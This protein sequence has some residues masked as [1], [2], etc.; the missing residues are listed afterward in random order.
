[1]RPRK[2]KIHTPRIRESKGIVYMYCPVCNVRKGFFLH[3]FTAVTAAMTVQAFRL[4]H[5]H[6]LEVNDAMSVRV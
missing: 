4:Q 5:E 2:Y 1:M 3:D 6:I